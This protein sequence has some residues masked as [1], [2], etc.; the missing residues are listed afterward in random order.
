MTHRTDTLPQRLRALADE[1]ESAGR[2]GIPIPEVVTATSL[3]V[4]HASFIADDHEFAAWADYTE[5]DVEEYHH[6]GNFW[7]R[8][9]SDVNGLRVEFAHRIPVPAPV[10]TAHNEGVRA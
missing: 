5:A 6:D 1:L 7:R 9:K 3:S 2:Y 4:F 8:A 10:N